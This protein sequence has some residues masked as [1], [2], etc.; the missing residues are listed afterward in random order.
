MEPT[1][2]GQASRLLRRAHPRD[3][4][5]END[6]PVRRAPEEAPPLTQP[7][8]IGGLL[9]YKPTSTLGAQIGRWYDNAGGL[10]KAISA[11]QESQATR[12]TSVLGDAMWPKWKPEDVTSRTA[13]VEMSD[14][15]PSRNTGEW[16]TDGAVYLAKGGDKE[17]QST[18]EHELSHNAYV[19][20]RPTF[21][22]QSSAASAGGSAWSVPERHGFE[23]DPGFASYLMSPAETDVRLAEVKRHYA[24][25][26]G[27]LVDS[28]AEAQK[29]WDWYR[30]YNRNFQPGV[31]PEIERPGEEPTMTTRQ[32][33]FYD[34]LP[35]DAKKQMLHRMP[36][37]VKGGVLSGLRGVG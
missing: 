37:L 30:S 7:S 27:R 16:S 35:D 24:H 20:D 8:V 4:A 33:E 19:R 18:L 15:L 6:L 21:R 13:T 14:R 1:D 3:A 31:N 26:T 25:H 11:A 17:L 10:K 12:D 9:G 36:E 2:R 22:G 28:P 5:R 32:F 34:S 23:H 29:A